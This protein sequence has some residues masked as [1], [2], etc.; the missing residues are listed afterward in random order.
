ML[1]GIEG[2]RRRGR[3]RMRWLNGITDS[4]TSL[5]QWVWVWVNSGS[6]W[7]I[8]RPGV[9][10][11]MGSQRVG[12]NWASELN[13]TELNYCWKFNEKLLFFPSKFTWPSCLGRSRIFLGVDHSGSV[14]SG[15]AVPL[16][17]V[18]S[19]LISRQ[20]S[21]IT[22]FSGSSSQPPPLPSAMG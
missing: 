16:Q 10:R 13:W 3:W 2:R 5:T 22:V 14:F 6:W 7:W 1:G 18:V 15:K 8:G 9:L 19:N 20:F 4:M 17:Y 12:H 21:W 11:F